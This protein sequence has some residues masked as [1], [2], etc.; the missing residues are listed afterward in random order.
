MV[1]VSKYMELFVNESREHLQSIS[2]NLLTLEKEPENADALNETF[3]AVLKYQP[4]GW[5]RKGK[6]RRQA[7]SV[8]Q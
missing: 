4:L 6:G 1:D 3:R 8:L 7:G 2:R 5:K